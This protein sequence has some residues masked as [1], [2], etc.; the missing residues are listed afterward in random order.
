VGLD[1]LM[2]REGKTILTGV[3]TN[4]SLDWDNPVIGKIVPSVVDQAL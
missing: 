1:F 4:P 2:N 3:N